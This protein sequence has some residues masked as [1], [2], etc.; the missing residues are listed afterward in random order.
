MLSRDPERAGSCLGDVEAV[1]WDPLTE[2][3]SGAGAVGARR[4]RAPRRGARRAALE[5]AR[6]ARDPR[7]PRARHAQ[8]RA[9]ASR[10][11][12]PPAGAAELLGGRLLRAPQRG[13]ARRGRARRGGTSWPGCA[14]SGSARRPA[15]ASSACACA[16]C[17]PGSCS[18]PRGGALAKM[19]PPFRLGVGGPVASGRQYISWIHTDDLVAHRAGRAR[20]RALE[21]A[22]QRH[23]ARAGGEPR[24][25]EG[26]RAGAA[27]PRGGPGSR[28]G[29]ARDVR[30]D[31]PDRH[32]PARASCRRRRWC[33]ATSSVHPELEE[34]LRS[35][36]A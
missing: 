11:R 2:A 22:D 33:S 5:R 19:L 36:L 10:V 27:P 3:G 15:P 1:H 16:R 30:R 7:Q 32:R 8:P 29:A 12:G 6:Q 4:G 21:R 28:A 20:G 26:A 17:A 35:A 18:T 25:L 9:G 24:V 23:R 31:G 14:W 13:A 34:A